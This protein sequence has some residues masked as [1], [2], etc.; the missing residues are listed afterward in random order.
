MVILMVSPSSCISAVTLVFLL[1]VLIRTTTVDAIMGRTEMEIFTK[2]VQSFTVRWIG[3]DGDIYPN[4]NDSTY[5]PTAL[6]YEG[7]RILTGHPRLFP[8]NSEFFHTSYEGLIP[9][10]SSQFLGNRS[11]I[12]YSS[13]EMMTIMV[14]AVF[15]LFQILLQYSDKILRGILSGDYATGCLFYSLIQRTEFDV[16]RK[17]HHT[18]IAIYSVLI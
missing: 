13:F 11:P 17:I 1:H 18:N 8:P 5:V 7:K 6:V 12:D 14:Q 3:P 16:F 15:F 4:S 10:T 2:T 9:Q